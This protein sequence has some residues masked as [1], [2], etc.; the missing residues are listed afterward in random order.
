[1]DIQACLQVLELPREAS[2]EQIRRAYKDLAAI[3]HPDR[4]ANNP[5]L[6]RRAEAKLKEINRAY[7]T[8][9]AL[10]SSEK[11]PAARC[12]SGHPPQYTDDHASH[13]EAYAELGTRLFLVFCSRLYS[14]FR[15]WVTEEPA[16]AKDLG[17]QED[18]AHG[19]ERSS[20]HRKV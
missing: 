11:D 19:K 1:M 14:R 2:P 18:K 6:R 16:E 13:A 4:F 5:R 9:E 20:D 8:L 3:W 12:A 17:G 15:D 7:E 10:A